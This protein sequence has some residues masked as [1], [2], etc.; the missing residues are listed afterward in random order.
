MM[1]QRVPLSMLGTAVC[2]ALTLAA[3]IHTSDAGP[4]VVSVPVTDTVATRAIR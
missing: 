3:A 4:T 2:V 1:T